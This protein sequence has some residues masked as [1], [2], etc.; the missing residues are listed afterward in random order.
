MAEKDLIAVAELTG[1]GYNIAYVIARGF[2]K[3]TDPRE[4]EI[5]ALFNPYHT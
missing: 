2:I 4:S 3:S 5:R 1:H